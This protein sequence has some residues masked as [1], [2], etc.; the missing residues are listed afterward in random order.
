[1][2]ISAFIKTEKHKLVAE[3]NLLQTKLSHV[4]ENYIF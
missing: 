4:S 2:L 1:M 3:V